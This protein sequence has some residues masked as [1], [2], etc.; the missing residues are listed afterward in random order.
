M[1]TAQN[2][3][4]VLFAA[5][6]IL[7]SKTYFLLF[8]V[9]AIFWF[10][11]RIRE[12]PNILISVASPLLLMLGS[13][14]FFGLENDQ[15]NFF[16][17]LWY[18]AKVIVIITLG[19]F[20]GTNSEFCISSLRTIAIIASIVS[21]PELFEAFGNGFVSL[22][23]LSVIT[24][25]GL[26]IVPFYM[27]H[28]RRI[29]GDPLLMQWVIVL[30]ILMTVAL[31][32]S[33]T[34]ILILLI[35][36]LGARG[37]LQSI[38]KALAI[39][40]IILIFFGIIIPFLPSYNLEE[41]TFLAKIRNSIQEISFV[42]NADSEQIT[43][44]WRGYESF[45]AYQQWQSGSFM[46]KIFGQGIG[47]TID[48]GIYYPLYGNNS[49]LVRY[50]PILHN[51]YFMILVKYGIFGLL[52]FIIFLLRLLRAPC[53]PY[54]SSSVFAKHLSFT[55]SLL[56]LITMASITGPLNISIMD[57]ITLL[58]GWAIGIQYKTLKLIDQ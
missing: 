36:W 16:K 31:S 39:G 21:L 51:G 40:V 58:C 30:P 3:L 41:I 43:A 8:F 44:N 9:L 28:S 20:I 33:R 19:V 46:K 15:Y 54:N 42:S 38:G 48:I 5:S 47:T 34:S 24:F 45:M 14:L 27:E 57:S 1:R 25:G 6:A 10:M 26:V 32:L 52:M 29:D 53:N 22:G 55:T 23:S 56:M 18:V 4:G 12:L 7:T 37:L 35:S 2:K 50:L 11:S 17:D 49:E 13:G